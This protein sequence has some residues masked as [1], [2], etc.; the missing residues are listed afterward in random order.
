[1]LCGRRNFGER[2]IAFDG[3][4]TLVL[5]F[6]LPL[7]P[8]PARSLGRLVLIGLRVT[9]TRDRQHRQHASQ[10]ANIDT[11]PMDSLKALDLDLREATSASDCRAKELAY[12]SMSVTVTRMLIT[13][14]SGIAISSAIS[15]V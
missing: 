11:V 8:Q 3:L 15:H 2:R 6:L 9:F 5:V 7:P 4:L 1:M 13:G 10:R 14:S 12:F